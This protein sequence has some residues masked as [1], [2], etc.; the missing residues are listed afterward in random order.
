MG[1]I[2][3]SK[4]ERLES[5]PSVDSPLKNESIDYLRKEDDE[6]EGIDSIVWDRKKKGSR[7]SHSP[8]TNQAK[9]VTK[10]KRKEKKQQFK[11]THTNLTQI[12]TTSIQPA[13]GEDEVAVPIRR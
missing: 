10:P 2:K 1:K 4:L 5:I 13:S 12:T 3:V 11:M 6:L 9:P 7:N 8:Y